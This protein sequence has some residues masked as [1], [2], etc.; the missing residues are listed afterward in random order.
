MPRRR[1]GARAAATKKRRRRR[2]TRARSVEA[3][4]EVEEEGRVLVEADEGAHYGPS[5]Y[6]RLQPIHDC[7][8]DFQGQ[9]RYHLA[10]SFVIWRTIGDVCVL[11]VS[12]VDFLLASERK[13]IQLALG[14]FGYLYF[15]GF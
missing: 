2:G 11:I 12:S 7:S 1:R 3:V 10:S 9:S 6:Q 4:V 5:L 8:E 13:P 14:G 15:L